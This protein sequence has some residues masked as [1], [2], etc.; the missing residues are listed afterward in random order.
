MQDQRPNLQV[1]PLFDADY[2]GSLGTTSRATFCNVALSCTLLG[3]PLAFV[4]TCTYAVR[5]NGLVVV[6]VLLVIQ[7]LL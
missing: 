4:E 6:R 2:L 1:R 7:F 5:S 3:T